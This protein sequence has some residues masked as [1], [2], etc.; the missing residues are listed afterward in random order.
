MVRIETVSRL[1]LVLPVP[2]SY[3]PGTVQ[4]AKVTFTVPAFPGEK[5]SGTIARIPDSLDVKTRTM[6]V[7]LDVRNRSGRLA[8]GMYPEVEWPV[9]RLHPTL[10]V[11]TS[12]AART[13]EKRFVVRVR[14]GKTEW[15]DVQPSLTSGNLIEVFGD[16]HEGDLVVVR[17]TDELRPGTSVNAR[18]V[19]ANNR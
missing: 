12:A 8:P 14:D 16:L 7:E 5:F 17:A 18:L 19:Q 2:E 13:N 10:F 4:G 6:P 15:V 1:R 9:R 11:P 3:V